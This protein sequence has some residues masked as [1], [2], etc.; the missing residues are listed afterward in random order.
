MLL[1]PNKIWAQKMDIDLLKQINTQRNTNL[2]NTFLHLS[3]SIY[4]TGTALPISLYAIGL[5]THNKKITEQG[6]YAILSTGI[7][8]GATL[9][10]KNTIR[11]QRP[12]VT[13]PNTLQP[14]QLPTDCSF[15]SGHSSVAFNMATNITILYPK[16]YIA[17]PAYMYAGAVAYS[18]MHI[19]VHY[20]TDVAVGSVLGIASA[21]ASYKLNNYLQ[22]NPRTKKS[23]NKLVF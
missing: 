7:N 14:L 21:W 23:Y 15:P 6:R 22:K 19:G 20:P 11:R 8:Y 10:L 13:Y 16:W 18:R 1:L 17:V 4:Y 12:F 3:N 9:L 5:V 2:D